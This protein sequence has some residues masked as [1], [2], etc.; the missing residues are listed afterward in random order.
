MPNVAAVVRQADPVRSYQNEVRVMRSD[1]ITLG[2]VQTGQ[3]VLGP[4]W[5]IE[6]RVIKSRNHHDTYYSADWTQ[7]TGG[8]C[9]VAPANGGPSL[10][11]RTDTRVC[12]DISQSF[13]WRY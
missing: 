12:R 2:S 13:G 10:D 11:R 8:E 4:P 9:L 7:L 6:R 1:R 3:S 5:L